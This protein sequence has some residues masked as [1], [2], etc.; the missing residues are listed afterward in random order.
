MANDDEDQEAS[1]STP[2]QDLKMESAFSS[3]L[4]QDK[5]TNNQM[6]N[7]KI[8]TQ[9]ALEDRINEEEISKRDAEIAQLIK[10]KQD[11]E[12]NINRLKFQLN[13]F[14][15]ALEES[16]SQKLELEQDLDVLKKKDASDG[17]V[18][19]Q[20]SVIEQQLSQT[21]KEAKEQLEEAKKDAEAEKQALLSEISRLTTELEE[22]TSKINEVMEESSVKSNEEIQRLSQQSRDLQDEI[23][24]MK[25]QLRQ[26]NNALAESEKLTD[27]LQ[28]Q[29]ETIQK[30]NAQARK[31]EEGLFNKIKAQFKR[32]KETLTSQLQQYSEELAQLKKQKEEELALVKD[33]AEEERQKLLAEI[34]SLTEELDFVKGQIADAK[35][36]ALQARRDA[37]AKVKKQREK[38]ERLDR[39]VKQV[40]AQEK[41]LLK[42]QIWSLE[43]DKKAAEYNLFGVQKEVKEL[44]ANIVLF[45]EQIKDLEESN[46]EQV[47]ELE[48]RLQ[49]NEMFYAK[50]KAT[51]KTKMQEMMENFQKKFESREKKFQRD[52]E[53][54]RAQLTNQFNNEKDQ[55]N[56]MRKEEVAATRLEGVEILQKAQTE[57]DTKLANLA[58]QMERAK[59]KADR[60]VIDLKANFKNEFRMER[61]K[62]EKEKNALITE[63]DRIEKEARSAYD[64]LMKSMTLKLL[65]ASDENQKL[66][67]TI[68]EKNDLIRGYEDERSSFRALARQTWKVTKAK[69]TNRR[70]R[71][72]S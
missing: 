33:S 58:N 18:A 15:R 45:E 40:A 49:A 67:Q 63:K 57:F 71:R 41:K 65:K 30:E 48:N 38:S 39:A 61:L 25:D 22:T 31:A 53:D 32:E 37:D 13:E 50:S 42:K 70:R 21:R 64:Q 51:A 62:A 7:A 3:R 60:K 35:N 66:R 12:T 16:E 46:A 52:V 23:K 28:E 10:Q 4:E 56:T 72:Q 44:R 24:F 14:K 26:V 6:D 59:V 47:E 54:L 17:D 27:E 5:Q 20:L 68:D 11:R 43:T 9:V 69:I 34:D 8:P 19:E 29:I 36:Q 1:S 2:E 55:L